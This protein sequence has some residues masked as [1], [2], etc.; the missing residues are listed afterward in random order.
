MAKKGFFAS[1]FGGG[2]KRSGGSRASKGRATSS[3]SKARSSASKRTSSKVKTTSQ[4]KRSTL[5]P[6]AQAKRQTRA[7]RKSDVGKI[8]KTTDGYFTQNPAITKKRRVAVIDQRDSDGALAVT[9]I[10]SKYDE[11]GKER[12]GK[13]YIDDLTLSPKKHSSL[14]QDSVVGNQVHIGTKKA[15]AQ[16]PAE[17][18]FQPIF[19]GDLQATSD[20]LTKKEL[21]TVQ[22]K[23]QSDT[24]EHRATH[25][26]TMQKWHDG[27]KKDK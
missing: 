24:P 27:F 18:N 19:K 21:K 13:A 23:L 3:K 16:T 6:T 17:K 26:R 1:L 4:A 7:R 8:Y 10:Y 22:K 15:G 2:G 25:E 9:K 20:K 5:K 14:K 12:K 11:N